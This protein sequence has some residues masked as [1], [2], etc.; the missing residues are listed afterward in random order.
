MNDEALSNGSV[1]IDTERSSIVRDIGHRARTPSSVVQAV[2]DSLL[3][4]EL[5]EEVRRQ[6]VIAL[7]SAVA[8][9]DDLEEL[10]EV[11]SWTFD[12][13]AGR[14]ALDDLVTEV[15]AEMHGPISGRSIDFVTSIDGPVH[16]AVPANRLRWAMLQMLATAD[17]STAPGGRI[18]LTLRRQEVGQA[19]VT[20]IFGGE[21]TLRDSEQDVQPIV[22]VL[23]T[24]GGELTVGS[25][26][27]DGRVHL[28]AV[29]P[30]D[31]DD[32]RGQAPPPLRPGAEPPAL[33]ADPHAVSELTPH[34]ICGPVGARQVLVVEDDDNLRRLLCDA[35][36]DEYRVHATSSA[37]AALALAREI[38][39]DVVIC[40]LV[41][42]RISGEALIHSF[43][44][45][46]N[47]ASTAIVVISGRTD[48]G[49][50]NRVLQDGAD[51]Y[52]AKP[53]HIAELRTRIDKLLTSF[54]TISGLRDDLTSADELSHQLQHAL[55]SRVLIEQAK[56][57]LAA[58]HGVGLDSGFDAMRAYARHHRRPIRDVA[59]S[60][61]DGDL[62]I[63]VAE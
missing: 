13:A 12:A 23:R 45:E 39:P 52:L 31:G 57:Y 16:V 14:T 33:G 20:V 51:D 9:H 56:G 27:A 8:L 43:R 49:V 38:A 2:L 1:H 3:Q 53:F 11:G 46:P 18:E 36:A 61:V 60:V 5:G 48:D 42:P 24:S 22:R 41:L 7:D 34:E 59:S 37:P 35:L 30:T 58:R 21:R 55:D 54:D 32:D 19:V 17:R 6:L 29:L 4:L 26:G 50:R 63:D 40:D 25:D 15:V 44:A 10:I 62:D 47:C 28:V